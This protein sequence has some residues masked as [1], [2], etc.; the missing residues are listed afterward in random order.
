MAKTQKLKNLKQ[1]R[2]DFEKRK[3]LFEG[4]FPL[5]VRNKKILEENPYI[6]EKVARLRKAFEKNPELE[7]IRDLSHPGKVIRAYQ[8]VFK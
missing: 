7:E 5:A 6:K 2:K 1:L 4:D 8:R 3:K